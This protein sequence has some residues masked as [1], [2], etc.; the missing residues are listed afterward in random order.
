MKQACTCCSLD[1]R[2]L[3]CFFLVLA[4]SHFFFSVRVSSSL[5]S[6]VLPKICIM[7][8]RK[9]I[10]SPDSFCYICDEYTILKQKLNIS[11]FVKKVYFAYFG[12]RL[13]DQDIAWAPH[14]VC[15]RCVEDL[16][17][18]FKGKKRTFRY[19]IPMIW[20]EQNNHSDDC[21]FCSC[22]VKGYN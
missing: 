3:T 5:Y 1:E 21:Y 20:R 18:W 22:D 19:G 7:A 9:C 10:N 4:C 12:L 11:D 13:G 15:K 6:T 2:V 8:Q 17:N 16:R 14:K